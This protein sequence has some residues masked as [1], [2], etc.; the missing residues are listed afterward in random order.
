MELPGSAPADV[1]AGKEDVRV[2]VCP[3]PERL[4]E[5]VDRGSVWELNGRQFLLKL[6]GIARFLVSDG[7]TVEVE[8][9]PGTDLSEALPFLMGTCF[10]ALLL[11]RG[12]LVLHGSAV[13]LDGRA[14]VFCGR[15]G[16]G[17]SS[18]AAAL[19]NMGCEFVNDDVCS[20]EIDEGGR[21]V[22]LP[23]G[24]RLKLFE[25]SVEKLELR[26]RECGMVRPGI[27]KHYVAPPGPASKGA[28]P[29]AA[30]YMLKDQKLPDTSGIEQ[31][32]LLVA[33]DALLQQN[34][35]PRLAMALARGS[36]QLE[37]T[38]AILRHAS[39]F[40]LTRTRDINKLRQTAADL[41]QQWRQMAG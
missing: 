8:P 15:S 21:P 34:Y 41:T 17:K 6:P 19:C 5:I 38:A 1:P 20:V 28:V 27:G 11:Q 35:R 9:A 16:I 18:L 23:D 25:A 33:A 22:I 30:V 2:C 29:L 39:V 37:I 26:G 7:R 31:L 4:Q 13:A 10:G 36:R 40:N 24:R 3:V 14:Y 32:S 12:G